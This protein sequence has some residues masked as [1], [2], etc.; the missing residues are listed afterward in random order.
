MRYSRCRCGELEHW[1][2]GMSPHRCARCPKC[3]SDIASGPSSHGEPLDHEFV[4]HEV[5]TDEGPKPLSRCRYCHR[6]RSQINKM[7]KPGG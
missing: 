7:D 4:A 5:E 6:T 3:G 2:S 1:G